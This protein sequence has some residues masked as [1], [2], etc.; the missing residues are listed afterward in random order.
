MTLK[1]DPRIK[2]IKQEEKEAREAKKRTKEGAGSGATT[3]LQAAQEEAKRKE[4]E[5]KAKEEA[6][7]VSPERH[8]SWAAGANIENL[9]RSRRLKQRRQRLLLPLL[10]K[11]LDVL[12]GQR[13]REG[14][15]SHTWTHDNTY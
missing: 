12:N 3:P 14:V 2:R 11:R 1:F 8:N 9:S 13:R 10:R 15:L 4:E 5:A 7:K 6:E